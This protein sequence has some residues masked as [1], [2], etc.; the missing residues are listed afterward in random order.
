MGIGGVVG[1][2]GVGSV[3]DVGGVGGV[4]TVGG[5]MLGPS[6]LPSAGTGAPRGGQ[7]EDLEGVLQQLGMLKYLSLF[8]REEIGVSDL[9]LMSKALTLRNSNPNPNLIVKPN[10]PNQRVGSCTHA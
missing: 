8:Q 10:L 9:A 3:G 2:G 1:I 6:A 5:R 4:G 7:P